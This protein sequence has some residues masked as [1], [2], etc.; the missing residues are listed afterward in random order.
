MNGARPPMYSSLCL[1]YQFSPPR[2]RMLH[3]IPKQQRT[4][5]W[6]QSWPDDMDRRIA[7]GSLWIS[8]VAVIGGTMPRS[9]IISRQISISAR[10]TSALIQLQKT[11]ILAPKSVDER[12]AT[13][14]SYLQPN[15]ENSSYFRRSG[16]STGY[17]MPEP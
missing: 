16:T 8:Q 2:D 15:K 1:H 5:S 9:N 6:N 7:K 12:S 11:C 13:W 17:F 14:A 10:P 3:N 4:R